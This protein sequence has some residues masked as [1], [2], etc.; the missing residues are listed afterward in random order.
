MPAILSAHPDV[1]V[2]LAGTF[3]IANVNWD[4]PC[5]DGDP[6]PKSPIQTCTNLLQMI[7]LGQSAGVKVILC[8]VPITTD[9]SAGTPLLTVNPAMEGSESLF[10]RNLRLVTDFQA[11]G[12]TEDGLV[13]LETALDGTTWTDDGLVFNASG[14]EAAASV[15]AAQIAQFDVGGTKRTS[16][17]RMMDKLLSSAIT[18]PSQI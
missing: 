9:G 4:P 16:N 12:W 2:I 7:A 11:A 13:D 8:T 5:D 17:L 6:N 3:D 14:A 10:N 1:V 18:M 15:I